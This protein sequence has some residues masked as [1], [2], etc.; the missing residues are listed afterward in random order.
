MRWFNMIEDEV[1]LIGDEFWDKIGGIGTYQ[2][3]IEAVNEI[4][5]DYRE[6]IYKDF[7]GIEPTSYESGIKL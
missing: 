2:A 3:F 7:L 5:I 1:V 4:G 6:Q